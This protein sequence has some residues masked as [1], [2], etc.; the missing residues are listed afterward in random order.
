MKEI[1]LYFIMNNKFYK[2]F[3]NEDKIQIENFA[4]IIFFPWNIEDARI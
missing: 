1:L 2:N 4:G 3:T